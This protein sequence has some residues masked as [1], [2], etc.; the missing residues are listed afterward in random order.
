MQ[1]GQLLMTQGE[2]DRL[3]AL[4]KAKKKRIKQNEAAKELGV[5]TRHVRRLLARLQQEGDRSVIHGLK[6]KPS[7]RRMEAD[8]ETEAVRILSAD[9]YR[10]FG[11]TLAAEYL[12]KKHH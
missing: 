9:V 8:I 5:S 6:G 11:P 1:E 7:H 10:G 3:I 4:K 2:R 12:Q